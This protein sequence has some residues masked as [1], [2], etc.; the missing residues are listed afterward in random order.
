MVAD[1][2]QEA[3]P[4]KPVHYVASRA[5]LVPFVSQLLQP[6]D[7]CLTFGAGDLTSVPDELLAELEG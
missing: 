5:E 7:L 1:A 6:G 3:F 2:V 4:D